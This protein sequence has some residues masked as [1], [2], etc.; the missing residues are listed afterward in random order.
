MAAFAQ[1]AGEY[2]WI[3]VPTLVTAALLFAGMRALPA[4][5]GQAER[6]LRLLYQQDVEL[7]LERLE[8]N[9]HLSLVFRKPML[10]LFRLEGYMKK[11]DD[12]GIRRTIAQLDRLNLPPRDRVEF[13]QKRLAFFASVGEGDE[14]RASRDALAAF[15]KKTKAD[16]MEKYQAMLQEADQIIAVYVDRD[17]S[18]IPALRDQAA[19]TDDPVRRGVIQYRLAKLYHF[20]GNGDMTQFYLKRAGKNLQKTVYEVMIKEAL[21]DH[22]VLERQ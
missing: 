11:G 3:I 8:N 13:C 18:A 17:T 2:A 5:R 16:R 12:Q 4:L 10:L 15:L 1:R 20:D 6:E 14:A 9:R 21:E 22:S 19:Q 7:Y